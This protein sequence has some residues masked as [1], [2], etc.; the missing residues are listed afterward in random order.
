MKKPYKRPQKYCLR[1]LPRVL[2]IAVIFPGDWPTG[3]LFYLLQRKIDFMKGTVKVKVRHF[4]CTDVV[5]K[6]IY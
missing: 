6:F 4:H 1:H 2:S 3:R 5:N